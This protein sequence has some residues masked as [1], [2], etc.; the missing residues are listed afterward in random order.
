MKK[1]L[2]ISFLF[3]VQVC[4]AATVDT[5]SIYS[6]AMHKEFKCVVISPSMRKLIPLPVVYLLH[7]WSGAFSDW[8]KKV[9]AIKEYADKYSMLIVCP[10]G[11]YS[12]WYFDSPIDSS[13]KYE[14]YISLEVPA[15]IDAHYKTI[16]DRTARAIAGLSMGGHGGMFLSFR[17]S[18]I[19]GA[20]GSMSGGLDLND[21]RNKFDILKRLGDTIRQADNWKNYSVLNVVENRPTESLAIIF[22]CGMDDFF[23]PGNKKLHEKLLLLKVPHDYIERPGQHD[24]NYWSNS[25]E[26][27]LLFFRK[28]FDK[29]KRPRTSN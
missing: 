16:K 27:H 2:L 10:D 11:G 19:F 17:H 12:S 13:M 26:Y 4:Y 21:A 9:P 24:W 15:Y 3:T 6:N 1:I 20:C 23:Y 25:V 5:I 18:D 14:T 22:D 29:Y 28:Y 8:I 7:G